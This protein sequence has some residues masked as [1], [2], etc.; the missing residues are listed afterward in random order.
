[1]IQVSY[2][3][4]YHKNTVKDYYIIFGNLSMYNVPQT[5]PV[6]ASDRMVPAVYK[7]NYISVYNLFYSLLLSTMKHFNLEEF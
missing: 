3:N 1:M 2:C 6:I 4:P 5:V 7:L